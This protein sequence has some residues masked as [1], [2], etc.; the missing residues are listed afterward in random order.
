L[1]GKADFVDLVF[2]VKHHQRVDLGQRAQLGR[3]GD[4]IG[5][6]LPLAPVVDGGLDVGDVDGGHEDGKC[7]RAS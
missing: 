7:E 2:V 5:R 3:K 1:G 4:A 6:R